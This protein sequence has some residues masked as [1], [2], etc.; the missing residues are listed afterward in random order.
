LPNAAAINE[1]AQLFSFANYNRKNKLPY[2]MNESLDV[3]WQPRSDLV[4]TIGYVGNLGRHEIIPVPFNQAGIATPSHPIHGQNYTYGY[5][6]LAPQGCNPTLNPAACAYTP[7]CNP[8]GVTT[9][10]GFMGLPDGSSMMANYEGGNIDLR[11]PYIGYSSESESYTAAGISAY[12]ALQVHVE[13]R[14]S[15]GLQAGFSYTYSHAT[16]EQSAMGLFYN[17]NNA[18][19]LRSG[20]GLSDFDRTH[21]INF[22]YFYELPKF[23]ELAS[24]RGRLADGWAVAG[25]AILQ[26]GQPY[27]VIDYSGAVGSLYY[28]TSDGITNPIVPLAPGCTP[29]SAYTGDSGTNPG[30]PALNPNC[31]T[32]PILNPGDLGGAI[33]AGDTF[34]TTYTTGQRNIFRQPWQRR[35]DLS[36]IKITQLTERVSARFTFQIFNLT[37]TPSFDI[38]INNVTQNINFDDFPVYGSPLY[39]SPT[40]SGI[41]IVNKTIGSPRQIQMSLKLTF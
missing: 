34:E 5:T 23:Y 37:N 1:G 29:S 30:Q 35:T 2:T 4:I 14:I 41:G 39:S 6:V 12:N 20:Y 31:F 36:I 32:V 27:S 24:L 19:D 17:G 33:P 22:T 25:L 28:G 10:C 18:T 3:Q 15:H 9:G 13:K 21:V 7:D 8:N 16:D 11:V 26:S 38:P 40:L